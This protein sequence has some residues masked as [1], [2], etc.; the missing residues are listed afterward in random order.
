MFDHLSDKFGK[1]FRNKIIIEQAIDYIIK[2]EIKERSDTDREI[3]H[4]MEL[5][6]N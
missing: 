1:D 4:W 2:E 6:M 3:C 5:K